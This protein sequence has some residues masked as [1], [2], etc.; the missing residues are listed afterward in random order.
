MRKMTI[1]VRGRGVSISHVGADN[2]RL[3]TPAQARRYARQLLV[4]AD[5][6]ERPA[7]VG[8]PLPAPPLQ[9]NT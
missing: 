5:T 9:E 1:G 2:P 8:E 3:I 6:A 4:A 7:D